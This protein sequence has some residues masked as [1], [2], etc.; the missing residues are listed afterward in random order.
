M[1]YGSQQSSSSANGYITSPE[2]ATLEADQGKGGCIV[3]LPNAAGGTGRS[4]GRFPNGFDAD[5]LCTD[6]VVQPAT[7]MPAAS[8]VGATNIKVASVADFAIGQTIAIDAGANLE[9]AVIATVGTAGATTVNTATNIGATVIPVAGAAGFTAG[10]TVTV[11][12]GTNQE[13]AVVAATAGGRQRGQRYDYGHRATASC[14]L[15][16]ALRSLE[17]ASV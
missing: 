13:T 1:V 2:I 5:S 7:T 9:S 10:Q 17:A 4:R 8:V 14:S 11:D 12:T 6:F 16:S 3:V 15:L